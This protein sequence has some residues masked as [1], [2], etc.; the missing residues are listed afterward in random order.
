MSAV[1]AFSGQRRGGKAL[2][3]IDLNWQEWEEGKNEW[4]GRSE[5]RVGLGFV[6]LIPPK[7]QGWVFLGQGGSA[8]SQALLWDCFLLWSHHRLINHIY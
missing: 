2:P 1:F 8:C 3:L 6:F 7:Q 5:E 4:W